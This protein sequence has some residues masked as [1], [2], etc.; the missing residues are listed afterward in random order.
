M[1]DHYSVAIWVYLSIR[2]HCLTNLLVFDV[3]LYRS[4]LNSRNIRILDH[5]WLNN[6]SV[7]KIPK[8]NKPCMPITCKVTPEKRTIS[9]HGKKFVPTSLGRNSRAYMVK[10][11]I[12]TFAIFTTSFTSLNS[13]TILIVHILRQRLQ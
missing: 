2:V 4:L 13:E 12:T 7:L 8:E 6:R 11:L 10:I 3:V 9:T 5:C 1:A